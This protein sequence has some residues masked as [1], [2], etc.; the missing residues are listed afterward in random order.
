MKTIAFI[1][2]I[3]LIPSLVKA[4]DF[5]RLRENMVRRQ[6]AN[7][8]IDHEPTL[9]AMRNVE[10]HLFVP[11]A[12][13][14]RAYDDGP[15]PIGYGQTISQPYIVAYMTQLVNPGPDDRVLEIGAGSGYQAA[16][17]AEIVEKVYTIEIIP[18]LGNQASKVLKDLGYEN[19]E[20]ITGDGYFGHEEMA[21]FDAIV[22]TAA[23]E[24]IPPPL[25]AQL[26]DGG[27]MVIPVGSPFLVQT[28]MLV[29][30]EGDRITTT[31]LMPV[32]FVPFTRRN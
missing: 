17:L 2:I 21:P 28:L 18:E 15:M 31:N 13:Q 27:K 29:E 23:A 32:R 12:Q 19:V 8:G 11:R 25:I 20:V 3:I 6:I 26:K 16:V 7:R 30:K 24:Y 14:R 5:D 4:Q 10:R 22:V 9:E 1:A